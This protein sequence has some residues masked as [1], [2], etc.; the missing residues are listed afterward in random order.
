MAKNGSPCKCG[1]DSE[2]LR[3]LARRVARL[4]KD[5]ANFKRR[6]ERAAALVPRM[7][8]SY[9]QMWAALG[10]ANLP[11][12]WGFLKQ[13]IK[14]QIDAISILLGIDSRA[15]GG[16]NVGNA[17]GLSRLERRLEDVYKK[18]NDA[19]YA[20]KRASEKIDETRRL[21]NDAAAGIKSV[22]NKVT[23]A[24][25]K[26]LATLATMSVAIA[27][28]AGAA[29][30]AVT[31]AFALTFAGL[32]EL[33]RAALTQLQVL[34][35]GFT[36]IELTLNGIRNV[37][38]RIANTVDRIERVVESV[39]NNLNRVGTN[40]EA[41]AKVADNIYGYLRN[42]DQKFTN[43]VTDLRTDNTR[44]YNLISGTR[45]LL[46]AKLDGVT[47]LLRTRISGNISLPT[48]SGGVV[49]L[50]F[51][52]EGFDGVRSGIQQLGNGLNRILQRAY[53]QR[54][55]DVLKFNAQIA[56]K[57]QDG[58][59]QNI[60]KEITS[61]K[62]GSDGLQ[63]FDSQVLTDLQE[64]KKREMEE[65][66]LA[67]ADLHGLRPGGDR[68]VL[69][70]AYKQR[71][72]Q[73]WG[74]STYSLSLFNPSTQ[75]LEYLFS[76]G[77]A[78]NP[79]SV[80]KYYAFLTLTDGSRIKVMSPSID[81]SRSYLEYLLQW[82]DPSVIPSLY[83]RRLITGSGYDHGSSI[84][85]LARKIEYYPSGQKANVSPSQFKYFDYV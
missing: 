29:A 41:I 34:T 14:T 78:I 32:Y 46:N 62:V 57:D 38:D 37:Q 80:G 27:G 19:A 31:K 59:W 30:I 1:G 72:G 36:A 22:S 8:S 26:I 74:Q 79:R 68:P 63:I 77:S 3:D 16:G 48:A 67:L 5:S 66:V 42:L 64:L 9:A 56:E 81:E 21:A 73:K 52:G 55:I 40:V 49:N 18:A 12:F 11:Q 69:V 23:G 75:A 70:I 25:R 44:A 82:I 33:T 47:L 6:F 71:L 51:V 4:E 58:N 84:Q 76:D 10:R 13:W 54:I 39:S 50:P 60:T 15:G 2:A 20:A 7:L 83:E 61:L 28:V 45:E 43:Y 53:Q 17:M 24:E 35:R 65:P 85:V